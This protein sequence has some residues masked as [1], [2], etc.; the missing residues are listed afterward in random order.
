MNTFA[1]ISVPLGLRAR[2]SGDAGMY[3]RSR[4]GPEQAEVCRWVGLILNLK[5]LKIKHCSQN[6][7]YLYHNWS[8]NVLY[9]NIMKLTFNEFVL[10][11]VIMGTFCCC[12]SFSSFTLTK[13]GGWCSCWLQTRATYLQSCIT[14]VY[15]LHHEVIWLFVG[16]VSVCWYTLVKCV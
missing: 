6:Y 10:F 12:W 14:L 11:S 9:L 3:G 15:N 7:L 8:I 13:N 4:V 16:A 5:L 1:H 2:W